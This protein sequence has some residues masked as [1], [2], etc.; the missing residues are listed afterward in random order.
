MKLN[1]ILIIAIICLSI[2][3]YNQTEKAN[4]HKNN[5]RA[6]LS[7]IN[8]YK[9]RDSLNAVKIGVLILSIDELEERH[10]EDKKLIEELKGRSRELSRLSTMQSKTVSVLEIPVRDTIII[11]EAQR[12]NYQDDWLTLDGYITDDTLNISIESRESLVIME[13]IKYRKFLWWRIGIK[14]RDVR[15]ISRNPRTIITDITYE[16]VD[17]E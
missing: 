15:A 17:G 7:G 8:E 6:L 1:I 13:T 10:S 12:I 3:C 14:S 11:K 2:M 4:I 16:M 5:E 9:V